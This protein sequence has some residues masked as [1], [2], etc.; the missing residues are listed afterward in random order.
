MA[1]LLQPL[2]IPPGWLISWNTL[3]EVDPS[4]ENVRLG[5]FGGSSLFYATDEHCRLWID[6]EW[7]PEDD[8][9]GEYRLKV[10]YVPWERTE[11]GRRRKGV[12]IDFGRVRVVHEYQT[13]L[14]A[15][16]VR[17]LEAAL[18]NRREWIEHS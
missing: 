15:D 5:Y 7:R 9:T 4:E 17:E 16:L 14:R 8:P 6:V 3:Y 10:E 11:S 18:A 13:R 12:P 2:R 1:V